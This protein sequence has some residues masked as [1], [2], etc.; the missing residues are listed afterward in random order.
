LTCASFVKFV[1][2]AVFFYNLLELKTNPQRYDINAG[3]EVAGKDCSLRSRS[4]M[5][6]FTKIKSEH[7]FAGLAFLYA[8]LI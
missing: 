4:Y 3:K 8:N 2:F 6:G 7:R 1:K 5:E